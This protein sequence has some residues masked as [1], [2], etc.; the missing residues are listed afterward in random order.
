VAALQITTAA[1][2]RGTHSKKNTDCSTGRE[3]GRQIDTLTDTQ[4]YW[5]T[6]ILSNRRIADRHTDGLDIL[7]DSQED[8]QADILTYIVTDRHCQADKHIDSLSVRHIER[9]TDKGA[10]TRTT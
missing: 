6:D 4:T 9:Q 1:L 8:S 10:Q 7:I 2:S 3:T 5:Q